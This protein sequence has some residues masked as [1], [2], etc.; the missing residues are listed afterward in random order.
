MTELYT[1]LFN[2]HDNFNHNQE[3]IALD[4]INDLHGHTDINSISRYYDIHAY[5]N[6]I[7]HNVNQLNILHIN[8]RSLPK[9]FDNINAFL[10]SL[11]VAPDILAITETWLNDSNK[12][13]FQ[14]PG[15][16]S[17]HLVRTTRAHGGVTIFT[18]VNLQCEQV[19]ELSFI[20]HSVEINSIR[21]NLDSSN[22]I[23]CA[24]RI[25]NTRQ[26]MNSLK[27]YLLIY[28]RT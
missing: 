17:F 12:H 27:F 2:L 23:L 20:N 13:L 22:I 1:S 9:N 7:P 25:A 14:L 19:Q 5:N 28:K 21:L 26:S 3:D 8:S 11:S 16:N 18:S 15:Y 4:I 10:N 6:F 24:D